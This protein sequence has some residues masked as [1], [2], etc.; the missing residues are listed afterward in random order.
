MAQNRQLSI[1]LLGFPESE[2]DFL[3]GLLVASGFQLSS[4]DQPAETAELR[5]ILGAHA[6]KPEHY[7]NAIVLLESSDNLRLSA[8]W[9]LGVLA[10]LPY[11]VPPPLLLAQLGLQAKWCA[12]REELA[13]HNAKMSA[14]LK[15][16][17]EVERAVGIVA[18]QYGMPASVAFE[19]LRNH[20][21]SER[22]RLAEVASGIVR[23]WE[24][25]HTPLSSI[26]AVGLRPDP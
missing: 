3:R 15:T 12:Q 10:V 21:R 6:S 8:L 4:G 1:T 22:L 24:A 7:R 9:E 25:A 19:R 13:L 17:R 23:N 14:L 11:P 2:A 18:G 5:L 26:A 20:A 16:E